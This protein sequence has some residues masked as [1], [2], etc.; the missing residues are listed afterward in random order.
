MPT[1]DLLPLSLLSCTW[2]SRRR[3]KTWSSLWQRKA[4]ERI[5]RVTS[6]VYFSFYFSIMPV[7]VPSQS[8]QSLHLQSTG[9]TFTYAKPEHYA[10]SWPW[11]HTCE[12]GKNDV[13]ALGRCGGI[14]NARFACTALRN[15]AQALA[16]AGASVLWELARVASLHL[17]RSG[18]LRLVWG[19][20]APCVSALCNSEPVLSTGGMR[21][22]TGCCVSNGSSHNSES[23]STATPQQP[24]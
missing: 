19:A 21:S 14:S 13:L 23:S 5:E 15:P 6:E 18:G 10:F 4:H 22:S 3:H 9:Q 20:S 16:A 17:P 8:P 2:I 12:N 24:P 11:K 7:M 1:D